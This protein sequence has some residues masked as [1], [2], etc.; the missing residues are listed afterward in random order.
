MGHILVQV[1]LAWKKRIRLKMLVDTGA[2][3]SVLPIDVARRLGIP[4]SP[5]K[6]KVE[7]ADGTRKEMGLG[8]V[9]VRLLGREA[10]DTVVIGP[11]GIEP[12]LGVEALEA[13]GLSLDPRRGTLK[14]SRSRGALLVGLR[15]RRR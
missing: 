6:V 13:L 7:L 11:K 9:L 2:T 10:G 5:R 14:P 15:T 1:D 8:T 4:K 3:H 12:L